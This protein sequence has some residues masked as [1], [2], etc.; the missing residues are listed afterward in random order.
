MLHLAMMLGVD[1][2]NGDVF[3]RAD[4]ALVRMQ[5][6][7]GLLAAGSLQE[8]GAHLASHGI[9]GDYAF[10]ALLYGIGGKFAIVAVQIA[11][12]LLAGFAVYR[13]A[14][15]LGLSAGASGAAMILY[16]CMPHSLVFPHQLVSEA[17]HVPLLIVSTWLLAETLH[18]PTVRLVCISALCLGVATLI[19]PITLLW[20]AVAVLALWIRGR[21]G[22]GVLYGA[23][24][25]L[26][27]I[28]WMSFIWMQTGTLGLGESS[29]SME[30]NLY[31]R[32]RRIAS[33]LP[34]AEQSE[35]RAEYLG[36]PARKLGPVAYLQFGVEHPLPFLRHVSRDAM[37]FFG[38][39]GVERITLDYLAGDRDVRALQNPKTGWRRQLELHGP[40]FTAR[41]LWDTLGATLIVSIAAALAM[42]ALFVL[43]LIGAAH[44]VRRWREIRTPE[45]V[46]G[47]LLTS[48]VVYTFVFSLVVDAVQS[49]Q[50]A[51]AEF[52]VV[53][54]AVCG[55]GALRTWRSIWRFRARSAASAAS[56]ASAA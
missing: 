16:L 3:L 52:A 34:P 36:S 41:Y 6:M 2:V 5:S 12:G 15:Q 9:V 28:V 27:V 45:V 40:L 55:Y 51:P 13:L 50:R 32:V 46:T 21:V 37:T 7:Q 54:L 8:L 10:H 43:A 11:L 24:A 30:H 26:P 31:E 4:R 56:P 23:L 48:L 19:R 14:G 17:L 33:T 44:F 22:E 47:W 42:L 20:P 29:H 49:R 25:A 38:K 53:L 18:R 1:A 39:S 35:V